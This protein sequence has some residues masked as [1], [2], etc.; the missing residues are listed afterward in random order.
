M[1]TVGTR[2]DRI[3]FFTYNARITVGT[4]FHRV[5]DLSILRAFRALGEIGAKYA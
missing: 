5:R 2:F 1:H 3:R 4:R